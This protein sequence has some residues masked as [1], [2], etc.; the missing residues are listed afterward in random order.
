VDFY[1]AALTHQT[2]RDEPWRGIPLE[3]WERLGKKM[4]VTL[5]GR[6]GKVI[7]GGGPCACE[8]AV[9]CK[10]DWKI[11]RGVPMCRNCHRTFRE[12]NP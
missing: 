10:H 8:S 3:T 11:E 6:C 12:L 5:C 9:D 1:G 7:E 4:P 2:S